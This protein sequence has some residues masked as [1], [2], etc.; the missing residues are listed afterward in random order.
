MSDNLVKETVKSVMKGKGARTSTRKVRN[1]ASPA[2]Q[3]AAIHR[4]RF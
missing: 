1:T 4:M 3:E 2:D